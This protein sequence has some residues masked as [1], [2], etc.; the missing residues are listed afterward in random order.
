MLLFELFLLIILVFVELLW[1]L[2]SLLR[3]WTLANTA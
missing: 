3:I 2:C 1:I